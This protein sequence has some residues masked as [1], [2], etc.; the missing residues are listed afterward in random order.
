MP[1][2]PLES[3]L[4]VQSALEFVQRILEI[5]QDGRQVQK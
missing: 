5:I 4:L 3:D 2:S 1:N